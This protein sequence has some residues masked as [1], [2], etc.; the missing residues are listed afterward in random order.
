MPD[1]QIIGLLATLFSGEKAQV[2]EM[3]MDWI[4]IVRSDRPGMTHEISGSRDELRPVRRAIYWLSKYRPASTTSE[5]IRSSAFTETKRNL[6][7]N[8][9]PPDKVTQFFRECAKSGNVHSL[10]SACFAHAYGLNEEGVRSAAELE[11]THSLPGFIAAQNHGSLPAVRAARE[12][13]H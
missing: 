8:G 4:A 5:V 12:T 2:T 1:M 9:I 3:T 6:P 10:V 13:A 7:S 11:S